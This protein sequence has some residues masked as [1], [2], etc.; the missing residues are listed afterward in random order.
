MLKLRKLTENDIEKVRLWRMNPEISKYMFSDPKITYEEQIEWFK[1]VKKD[2]TRKYWI[3]EFD[4]KDIGLL[5]LMNIDLY[6]KN[7]LWAYYIVDVNLRGKGIGKNLECNIHDYV[8]HEL[9]LNKIYGDALDE[10]KKVLEIHKHFGYRIEGELK[11]QIYKN[12]KFHNLIKIGILSKEWENIR[13]NYQYTK[14][15]IET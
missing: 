5:S 15:E 2:E 6:N 14:I 8:F 4:S 3:I 11:E 10:N 1:T 9:K 12:G 7:C 13:K